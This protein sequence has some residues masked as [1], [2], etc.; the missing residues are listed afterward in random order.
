MLPD[1]DESKEH[2]RSLARRPCAGSL[3][4]AAPS[5]SSAVSRSQQGGGAGAG[6]Q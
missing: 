4:G 2:G 5:N 6:A 1:K 3:R